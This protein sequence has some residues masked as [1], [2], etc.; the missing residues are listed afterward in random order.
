ME[1]EYEK[2]LVSVIVATYKNL[3]GIFVTLDGI[4]KQKYNKIEII[5]SDDGTP[6]ADSKWDEIKKYIEQNKGENI[7]NYIIN[8]I[9]VN[10]GT[11]KNIN[12]AIKLAKGEYITAISA[13]DS[14]TDENVL[15]C[16]N[17]FL[18]NSKYLLC[19]GKMRGVTESGEYKYKLLACEDNYDMLRRLSASQMHNL[20]FKRNCLPA[21]AVMYKHELFDIYGL[22]SESTRIIEDYPFWLYLSRKNV[23]FGYIDKITIDY[24]LSGVSSAGSYSK[25]FMDDMYAIYEEEIFPYDHR[26][27]ILQPIYNGLKRYG[28]KFYMDKADW[29]RY[30]FLQ[31][32]CK[33]IIYCPLFVYTSLLDWNVKR[34]NAKLDN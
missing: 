19:F 6:N 24:K 27:G 30:S 28:L 22:H 32:L 17:E 13:E 23:S 4:F 9:P 15:S 25:M 2:G 16:Y 29:G 14:F 8:A 1:L 33:Y 31:K 26:F 7:V 10:G 20:L 3:D 34:K 11:V 5:I 21:P 18:E 12:S